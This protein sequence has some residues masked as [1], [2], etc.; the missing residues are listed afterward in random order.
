MTRTVATRVRF[1]G[2]VPHDLRA[3]VSRAADRVARGWLLHARARCPGAV[4][5]DAVE[6]VG[7][8]VVRANVPDERTADDVVALLTSIAAAPELGFEHGAIVVVQDEPVKPFRK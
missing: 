4:L 5:V 6:D 3:D 8:L 7:D 1:A 2:D